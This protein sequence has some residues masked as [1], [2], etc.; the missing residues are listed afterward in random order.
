MRIKAEKIAEICKG[1]ILIGDKNYEIKNFS[2]DTRSINEGDMYIALKGE[3][4]NGNLF[5]KQAFEKGAKGAIIEE[6]IDENII[7]EYKDRIIIKVED[8]LKAL[9]N[10]A[11]Y[12]RDLYNIPVIA[13][14]G[15]VGKTSTK[16]IIAN[17]VSQRYNVLKTEG[18][19]NNHIGLPITLLKLDNHTAVVVEMGMN[20]LGE[21]SLLSKIASPTIAVITNVGTAH[22]GYLGSR[23][24]ILK[25]KLEI[26]EGMKEN[27]AFIINNDND[28]LNEW[29]KNNK[30]KN[31]ITYGIKNR[32]EY[33]GYNICKN[34]EDSQFNI[35]IENIT[36]D[37][38]VL[39]AGEHFIYN[40]LCAIAVGKQLGISEDKIKKGILEFKLSAKRMDFKK[41]KNNITVLE[42]CYNA[43]YDSMKSSLEVISRY[44]GARKIAVLGNMMELGEFTDELHSKV[45]EE[46][47]KNKIDILITVG[48]FAKNIAKKAQEL[49]MKKIYICNNNKEAI[50]VLKEIMAKDDII[51]MKASNSMNF[52]EIL[53]SIM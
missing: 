18:N 14:T 23:E 45:G 1:E 46:V 9:Q 52:S 11:K 19:Y 26:L 24:N 32:S 39:V 35:D 37:I 22:I 8:G 4:S 12:K 43:S 25:A 50:K 7:N 34:V 21:I 30:N 16:D 40:S 6:V 31:A 44:K 38:K 42:D 20:H 47:Y 49:G 27:G 28:L 3:N 17:V 15:S 53:E 36:Y 10:L 41:I 48:E 29:N 33:T 51:L 13:V 5:L 2:I